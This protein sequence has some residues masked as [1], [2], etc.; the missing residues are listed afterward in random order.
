VIQD[1]IVHRSE[2]H[3]DGS[4]PKP[5]PDPRDALVLELSSQLLP[6]AHALRHAAERVF[7]PIGLRTSRVLVLELIH[8]GVDQPKALAEVLETVPSAV[9]AILADLESRGLIER[10]TDPE[11][12][13]RV[14]LRLSAAGEATYARLGA[15][16]LEAGRA[17]LEGVDLDDLHAVARVAAQVARRTAS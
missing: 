13:R 8:R 6:F 16:W 7:A 10:T 11:D 1:P 3:D 2:A 9:T 15:A 14:R 12:R 5:P 4:M 17:Y